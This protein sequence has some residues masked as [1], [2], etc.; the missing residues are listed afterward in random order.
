MGDVLFR[1][2][3]GNHHGQSMGRLNTRALVWLFVSIL[4]FAVHAYDGW[5]SPIPGLNP[6][7]CFP[8]QDTER[9]CGESERQ[10]PQRMSEP[11]L[12][13]I[14]GGGASSD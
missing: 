5:I 6:K 1:R 12:V 13:P 7:N 11:A 10:V 2:L 8:T 9:V 3:D 14:A 4:S